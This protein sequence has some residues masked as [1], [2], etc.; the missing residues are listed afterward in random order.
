MKHIIFF[1][2]KSYTITGAE[3]CY[4]TVLSELSIQAD[5]II[6]TTSNHQTEQFDCVILT[7][8]VPHLLQL[9]GDIVQLLGW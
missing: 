8:P 9:Q 2:V 6:A 4:D 3:T 5:K 1:C 7:M